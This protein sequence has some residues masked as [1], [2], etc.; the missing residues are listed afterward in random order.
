MKRT[1]ILA[2]LAVLT[3]FSLLTSATTID[4]SADAVNSTF[5]WTAIGQTLTSPGGN[6]TSYSF[7]LAGPVPS[8]TFYVVAGDVQNTGVGSALFSTSLSNLSAGENTVHMNIPTINGDMYSILMDLNGYSGDSVM[9]SSNTYCCG[10]GEWGYGTSV[11]DYWNRGLGTGFIA[12][13]GA[14]SVPEP[15]SL[16]LLGSGIFFAAGSIRRKLQR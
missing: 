12:V 7:F 1:T 8:M 10:W 3:C 13:F 6:L 14:S 11:T 9:W 15:A 4:Q 16:A 2:L 5:G